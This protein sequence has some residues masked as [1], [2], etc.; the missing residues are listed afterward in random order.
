MATEG[1]AADTWNSQSDYFLESRTFFNYF[2]FLQIRIL[3]KYFYLL[4]SNKVIYFW[5]HWWL[6]C[7]GLQ[8][9][10]GGGVG[11]NGCQAWH[12]SL[13][14]VTRWQPDGPRATHG[15]RST[16]KKCSLWQKAK[17][18]VSVHW[19]CVGRVQPVNCDQTRGATH[20]GDVYTTVQMPFLRTEGMCFQI[21]HKLLFTVCVMLV[22]YYTVM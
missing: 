21:I 7:V 5:Q 9:G 14:C 6:A 10:C 12:A 1:A 3:G 4:Q 17:L 15:V 2:Y 13:C 8:N 22:N 18:H 11:S 19:T 16:G 20:N